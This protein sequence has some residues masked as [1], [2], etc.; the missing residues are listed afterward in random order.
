MAPASVFPSQSALVWFRVSV[1]FRHKPQ[2]SLGQSQKFHFPYIRFILKPACD[3][4]E[5]SWGSICW[6]IPEKGFLLIKVIVRKR[7]FYLLPLDTFVCR[8]HVQV[9]ITISQPSGQ[10]AGEWSWNARG[11]DPVQRRKER[12]FLVT[13]LSLWLTS[14]FTA[15]PVTSPYTGRFHFPHC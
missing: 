7:F 11:I 15:M 9:D 6:I 1:F 12:W 2:A 10:P 3:N 8:Y 13:S 5:E 4:S 14:P